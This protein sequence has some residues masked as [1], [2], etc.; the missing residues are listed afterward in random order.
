MGKSNLLQLLFLTSALKYSSF[1]FCVCTEPMQINWAQRWYSPCWIYYAA[2]WRTCCH[3][4]VWCWW[5]PLEKGKARKVKWNP[6]RQIQ[7]GIMRRETSEVI[8]LHNFSN[9]SKIPGNI[10]E[11]STECWGAHPLYCVLVFVGSFLI[12]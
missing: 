8:I 6:K 12:L 3:K 2:S 11:E 5:L 9:N 1:S 10:I 7:M 4:L